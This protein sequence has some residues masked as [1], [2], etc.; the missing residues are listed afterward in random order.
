LE[1]AAILGDILTFYQNLYA[2]ET[3]LTTARETES[4]A[5]LVQLTGYRLSPGLSGK[6][7]FTFQVSGQKDVVIPAN[8]PIT[9][10][11]KGQEEV[12]DFEIIKQTVAVPVLSKFFLYRPYDNQ[13]IQNNRNCFSINTTELK[14]SGWNLAVGDR[15]MLVSWSDND[16]PQKQI[17]VIEK[18]SERFEN[19]EIQ[20]E[21]SW[22]AGYIGATISAYKLGRSFRCFGYNGPGE[23]TVVKDG[24]VKQK[25]VGF[26]QSGLDTFSLDQEVDDISVGSNMLISLDIRED[27]TRTRQAYFFKKTITQATSATVTH[28]AMTGGTT[29]I[30]LDTSIVPSDIT[31]SVDSD[32]RTIEFQEVIGSALILCG[33]RVRQ[34]TSGADTSTL[35][36]YGDLKSYKKLDRRSILFDKV[37]TTEKVLVTINTSYLSNDNN[38]TLR[39]LTLSKTLKNFAIEDFP[40]DKPLV[41]VYGNL[42]EA[43]Q[44]K[45]EKEVALGNGDSREHF[46]TFK[47]PKTPLTYFR[48]KDASPPELPQ[49]KIYVDNRLW[50][51]VPSFFGYTHNDAIY[52]V[53]QD[54]QG[55]SWIQFG[56][57][58]TGMRLPSGVKNVVAKYRTGI[59]AYGA[60]KED[61]TAQPGDTLGHLDGIFLPGVAS[62]GSQPESGDKARETAPGKLQALGRLVSLRDYES[63]ALN[64]PGVAKALARW[65]LSDNIPDIEMTVLMEAKREAEFKSVE[66]ILNKSNICRGPDRYPI[67]IEQGKFLYV[68]IDITFAFDPTLKEVEMKQAIK[69]ALGISGS[70]GDGIDGS[71][72]LFGLYGRGFG[73]NE[74]A[75]RIV[76]VVQNVEGVLW[77]KVLKLGLLSETN[78]PSELT[79]TAA[80]K[81]FQKYV[82][83]DDLHILSL[84]KDHLQLSVSQE[85][86]VQGCPDE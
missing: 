13:S 16:Q 3:F 77:A 51:R 9:A 19:T 29:Q 66:G 6:A 41:T 10:Q 49:L 18:L 7:L 20:I 83:C 33:V 30:K 78:D 75:T 40:L 81:T 38:K 57:G 36:F 60:L 63:E 43:T 65:D 46:Q 84:Y 22:Q 14:M 73:Q 42:A 25:P 34:P 1:G 12:A 79:I 72:G 82:S 17:V 52:I 39:P 70:E 28:G 68:Y 23:L 5:D 69:T 59:G 67:S 15:L 24:K 45:T 64:I 26:F 35:H 54:A 27:G 8:F 48:S 85:D 31:G 74:Y 11:V 61:T 80:A 4:I 62:G 47:L 21:G 58:K 55:D 71:R 44:G 56:D 76:G 53:R 86:S 37:G 32:I 50:K 2:N